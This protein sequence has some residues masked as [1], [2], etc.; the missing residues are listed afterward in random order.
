MAVLLGV[1]ITEEEE[2]G[3]TEEITRLCS[4]ENFKIL[5]WTELENALLGF[6]I[7]LFSGKVKW[8]IGIII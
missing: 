2:K 7:V 4:F 6:Q 1:S 3:I 5:R 8:K